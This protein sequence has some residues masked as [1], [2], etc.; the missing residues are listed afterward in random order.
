MDFLQS[1]IDFTEGFFMGIVNFCNGW[2]A[3]VILS[4]VLFVPVGIFGYLQFCYK[5]ETNRNLRTAVV[6]VISF[7]LSTLTAKLILYILSIIC[8]ICAGLS[9]FIGG[10]I[11][12]GLIGFVALI[13]KIFN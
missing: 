11:F 6:A 1:A 12:I 10:L 5:I 7:V 2:I 8:A 4:L 13:Y 3:M 9:N